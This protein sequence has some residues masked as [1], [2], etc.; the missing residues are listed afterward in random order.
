MKRNQ[1]MGSG[2]PKG[3]ITTNFKEIDKILSDTRRKLIDGAKGDP[4]T[5]AAAFVGKI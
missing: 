5:I 4:E 2:K 3:S 1:D